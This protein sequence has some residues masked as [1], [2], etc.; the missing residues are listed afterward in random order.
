[1]P[2][3]SE[4]QSYD[5]SVPNDNA[6]N[7]NSIVGYFNN[8]PSGTD[9]EFKIN[10]TYVSIT[11]SF[12]VENNLASV[13]DEFYQQSFSTNLSNLLMPFSTASGNS[14]PTF[15]SSAG[16]ESSSES[17]V[18][19][20]LLPFEWVGHGGSGTLLN[21]YTYPSGGFYTGTTTGSGYNNNMQQYMR[22][23]DIRSI[24]L[25]LPVIGIGWGYDTDDNP[26]PES[27]SDSTKF[28]GDVDHGRLIDPKEYV[29]APIDLRYDRDRNVW[30]FIG[31]IQKHKHLVN[32]VDDGGPAYASF[33]P[34]NLTEASGHGLLNAIPA[35]GSW[36]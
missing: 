23:D 6:E 32:T 5:P 21:L 27:S 10:R 2:L 24:G 1:M 12:A 8:V 20:N 28:I 4:Y 18:L 16:S 29:A 30:T 7:F 31:G 36:T 33:F 19:S 26:F 13:S 3:Y 15:S 22:N 34:V 25:R 14:I 35:L 9:N 17:V 11:D